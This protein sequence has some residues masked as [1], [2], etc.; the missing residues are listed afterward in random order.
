MKHD[1]QDEL[2]KLTRIIVDTVPV[3]RI[4]LFG[5]YA[6]EEQRKDSDLDL[7]VVMPSNSE[8]RDIDAMILIRRAIRNTKTLPVDIVV[9]HE[10]HFDQRL[11]THSF[12][13]QVV[14][15]GKVLYG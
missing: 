13:Q 5:S 1:I 8:L 9:S 12:E 7:Y 2:K 15:E 3:Q 14:R 10:S 11:A 4:L 6:R